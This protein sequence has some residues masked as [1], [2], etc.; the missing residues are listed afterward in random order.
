MRLSEHVGTALVLGHEQGSPLMREPFLIPSNERQSIPLYYDIEKQT[1]NTAP[2]NELTNQ[3]AL[4]YQLSY[5]NIA[6]SKTDY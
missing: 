6:L 5:N 1:T 4:L 3:E 2:Y